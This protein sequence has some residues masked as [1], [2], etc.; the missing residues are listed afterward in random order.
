MIIC[1]C[2][3]VSDHDIARAAREGC[4]TFEAL[5]FDL[6]VATCCGKCHDSAR[7]TLAHHAAEVANSQREAVPV[8]ALHQRRMI[9]I[10]GHRLADA[11]VSAPA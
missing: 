6:K 11:P 3:R 7:E 1:V 8:D 9:P 2:H 4:S 5:Q 10:A